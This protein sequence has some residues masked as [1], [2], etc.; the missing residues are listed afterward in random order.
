[1]ECINLLGGKC[2]TFGRGVGGVINF[3][4]AKMDAAFLDLSVTIRASQALAWL[5]LLT[6]SLRV[7]HCW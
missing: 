1:M 7:F 5:P 2:V 3:I 6:L 4:K